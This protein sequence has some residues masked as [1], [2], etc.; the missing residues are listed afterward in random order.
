MRLAAASLKT[1]V[2]RVNGNAADL[3]TLDIIHPIGVTSVCVHN[4]DTSGQDGLLVFPCPFF[5][6]DC[7]SDYGRDCLLPGRIRLRRL[8]R[9]LLSDNSLHLRWLLLLEIVISLILHDSS[10]MQWLYP[11]ILFQNRLKPCHDNCQI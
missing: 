10:V 3:N 11:N 7:A 5:Y 8:T 1:I 6:Q 9:R 2:N 4:E